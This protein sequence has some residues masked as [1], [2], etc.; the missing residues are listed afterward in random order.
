[1]KGG[2]NTRKKPSQALSLSPELGC[3]PISVLRYDPFRDNSKGREVWGPERGGRD[4][5]Q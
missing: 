3:F 4:P 2:H 1:M 5:F